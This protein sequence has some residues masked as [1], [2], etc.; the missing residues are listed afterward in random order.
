MVRLRDG[1]RS[2][3]HVEVALEGAFRKALVDPEAEVAG[4]LQLVVTEEV[5]DDADGY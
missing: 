2:S 5:F 1:S 4:G 3:G